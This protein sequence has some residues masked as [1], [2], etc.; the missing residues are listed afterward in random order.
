MKEVVRD[1]SFRNVV[2]ETRRKELCYYNMSISLANPRC[3]AANDKYFIVPWTKYIPSLFF[4][5]IS[6]LIPRQG[7]FGVFALS[8]TGKKADKCPLINGHPTAV[9]AMDASPH[10]DTHF[11]TGYAMRSN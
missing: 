11:V 7:N 1:S 5:A 3:I 4:H 6:P 9:Y 8:E 2:G 10:R